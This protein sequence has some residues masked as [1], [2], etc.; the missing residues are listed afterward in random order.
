VTHYQSIIV[1]SYD[2]VSASKTLVVR[3]SVSYQPPNPRLK[4]ATI[5]FQRL[6]KTSLTMEGSSNEQGTAETLKCNNYDKLIKLEL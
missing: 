4:Q 5:Q 6:T 1:I 3:D 2:L